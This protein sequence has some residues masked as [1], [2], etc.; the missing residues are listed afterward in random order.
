[1]QL[2]RRNIPARRAAPLMY[3]LGVIFIL[4]S[5]IMPLVWYSSVHADQ[6][7]FRRLQLSDS[8]AAVPN[9]SYNFSFNTMT[10]G[11]IGSITFQICSNYQYELT[12]PCTPPAG[13]DATAATLTAQSGIT[14]FSLDNGEVGASTA[15]KL[16]ITR[17]VASTVEPQP[18][19]YVFSGITNPSAVSTNYVRIST[20]SSSD[21]T[22]PEIDYG[23]VV[24]ATNF[25][26]EITTEVPPY[27]LFCTGITI[28]GFNCGTAEGSFINFGELSSRTARTA[29][30]QML[31]ST[32]APFGYSVT[33]TGTTMT[34]GNNTI[35][36]MNGDISRPGTSQFG[37]NGRFNSSPNVGAEPEGGGTTS[38]S[39]GYNNPNFFRFKD[40][41]I[42]AS[43]N[44]TDDYRKI[45]VSYL[46]NTSSGQPPGRYVTTIS[47][48]CLANF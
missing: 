2:Y 20:H 33:M 46:V 13:F 18:L 27:L 14:D 34:A 21:G 11:P 19:A 31:A 5:L 10:T 32:N 1:M 45:T 47:Y 17:P 3:A 28:E 29:T 36:S 22:G 26:I 12:D 16:V 6:L 25:D 15:S 42:I 37:V 8:T 7:S 35:P 43:S 24:F 39:A 4:A 44:G 38:P 48:I 41:D 40:G 23:I 9:V 30:S